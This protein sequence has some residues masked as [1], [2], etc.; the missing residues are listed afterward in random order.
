MNKPTLFI[1]MDGP[2]LVPGPGDHALNADVT[3]YA[4]SFLNWAMQ[5]FDTRLLTDR[6]P[7]DGFHL[8][9]KL[10]LPADKFPVQTFDTSKIE[11]IGRHPDKNFY[12][13]DAELIPGEISWLTQHGHLHKFVS[14][15]PMTGITSEHK[16]VLEGHLRGHPR[17]GR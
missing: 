14:V 13:L 16:N 12:W 17:D 3:P 9:D 2:L 6:S 15:D 7:R 10:A 8:V 11:V 5:H 4:K 1:N